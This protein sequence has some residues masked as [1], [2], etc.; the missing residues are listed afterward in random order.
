[1]CVYILSVSS[2]YESQGTHTFALVLLSDWTADIA[3][4]PSKPELN[5][6]FN[7]FDVQKLPL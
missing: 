6:A 3:S 5:V 1:M 7:D 4:C 2:V